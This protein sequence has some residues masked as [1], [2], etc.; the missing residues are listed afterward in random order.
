MNFSSC[1][2]LCKSS[3]SF[4]MMWCFFKDNAWPF[5][6]MQGPGRSGLFFSETLGRASRLRAVPHSVSATWDQTIFLTTKGWTERR[7][8]FLEVGMGGWGMVFPKIGK[9]QHGFFLGGCWV[10][11]NLLWFECC[12]LSDNPETQQIKPTSRPPKNWGCCKV[13]TCF[14]HASRRESCNLQEKNM[15][16]KSC[17][18]HSTHQTLSKHLS[19]I[20]AF[21][22]LIE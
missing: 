13:L 1:F 22:L 6:G 10:K 19:I 5:L 16:Y 7:C 2:L 14:G 8:F 3:S 20:Q 18:L 12:L 9:W 11:T 17:E 21:F 15:S 4:L